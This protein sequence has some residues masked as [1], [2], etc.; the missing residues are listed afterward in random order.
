MTK[1]G[2]FYQETRVYVYRYFYINYLEDQN[3]FTET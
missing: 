1:S 3:I 2:I